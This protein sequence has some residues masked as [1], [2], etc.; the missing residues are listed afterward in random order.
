MFFEE[1][2]AIFNFESKIRLWQLENPVKKLEVKEKLENDL[3][4]V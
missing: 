4:V 1:F 2:Y 3:G